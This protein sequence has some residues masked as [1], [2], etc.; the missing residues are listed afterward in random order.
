MKKFNMMLLSMVAFTG[1]M[2]QAQER[3][4][5]TPLPR[6][7]FTPT[8]SVEEATVKTGETVAVTVKEKT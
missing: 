8:I 1:S 7:G 2:I 4:F 5:D 3:N 6:T